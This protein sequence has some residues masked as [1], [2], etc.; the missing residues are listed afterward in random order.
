MTTPPPKKNLQSHLKPY[1]SSQDHARPHIWNIAH[2]GDVFYHT[3]MTRIQRQR[4]TK[5]QEEWVNVPHGVY[6]YRLRCPLLMTPTVHFKTKTDQRLHYRG[7]NSW[8]WVLVPLLG[9]E[10]IHHDW[11]KTMESTDGFFSA[12]SVRLPGPCACIP[13]THVFDNKSFELDPHVYRRPKKVL[14][15]KNYWPE[16]LDRSYHDIA[17]IQLDRP[18]IF[19]N[20]TINDWKLQPIC[21]PSSSGFKDENKR[22]GYTIQPARWEP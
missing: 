13:H 22:G 6:V 1:K 10:F 7:P 4:Q 2:R 9:D 21:L 11:P 16:Q 12:G 19:N 8:T 18:Y 17:L 15:H 14:I 3:V 20:R 5:F